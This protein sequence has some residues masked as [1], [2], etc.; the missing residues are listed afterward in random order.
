MERLA[1]ESG[2][3]DGLRTNT[4]VCMQHAHAKLACWH[5]TSI[6]SLVLVIISDD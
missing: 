6:A 5:D 2:A 3:R 1:R 4:S